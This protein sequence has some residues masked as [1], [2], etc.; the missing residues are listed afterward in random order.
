[1]IAQDLTIVLPELILSIYAMLALLLAVYTGKDRMAGLVL[2]AT[3]VV[4]TLTAVWIALVP[5]GA[6]AACRK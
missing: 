5:A 3:V 1:M 6:S 4:L 2:S